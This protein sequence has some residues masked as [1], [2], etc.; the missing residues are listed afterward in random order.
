LLLKVETYGARQ[1]KEERGTL[2]VFCGKGEPKVWEGRRG[3]EREDYC[4]ALAAYRR[5]KKPQVAE[6]MKKQARPP[7]GFG[8]TKNW[9]GVKG[10]AKTWEEGKKK[11]RRCVL[12]T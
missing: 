2:C 8:N 3:G 7:K 12:N 5:L 10:F 11:K 4:Y 1:S 6:E 9:G